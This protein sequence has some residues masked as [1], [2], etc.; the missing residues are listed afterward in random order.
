M[1]FHNEAGR[2]ADASGKNALLDISAN[3]PRAQGVWPGD[4]L[5][6]V[7][8]SP[9][10]AGTIVKL[11]FA[12]RVSATGQ[13][14]WRLEF[15]DGEEWKIVGQSYTNP[16]VSGPDGLPV[17]YT[18]AMESDGSTN[19]KVESLAT[20]SSNTD[21]VEFRF[22][23]AANYKANDSG[24]LPAPN[25]GTWRLAVDETVADAV[26]DDPYQ[27]QISIV[28]AGAETLTKAN[29]QVTPQYLVFEGTGGSSRKFSVDCDQDFTLT[30]S[31]DWIHLN[32]TES[33]AGNELSFSVSCDD[34]P[35]GL[36]R[37][38]TVTVK[39]GF[40]RADI[41]IIQ[42]AAGG[43]IAPDLDPLISVVGGN[44]VDVP[45]Q[46]GSVTV[47]V[48]SN[49]E[50]AALAEDSWLSV[51]AL[52]STKAEVGVKE[53]SVSYTANSDNVNA[54]QG[55][56]VFYN[57]S[58][59]LEAVLTVTQ[60]RNISGEDLSAKFPIVWSFP[61]PSDSW[62]SGVDYLLMTHS[63]S[64]TY[65]YS[66]DHTG[67]IE[68]VRAGTNASLSDPTYLVKTDVTDVG[69]GKTNERMLLH[70]G[71]GPTSYWQFTVENV[72]QG[73]GTYN[74]RYKMC[75]SAGGAK[76]FRL[77]YTLEDDWSNPVPIGATSQAKI[78]MDS[79][80]LQ[81]YT[82]ATPS[83]N[84]AVQVDQSFTLPAIE[85]YKTLKIRAIVVSAVNCGQTKDCAVNT[86][87][88]NRIFGTPTISFTAN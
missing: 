47:K 82:Y 9:V 57:L 52:P 32:S 43:T 6:I 67:K 84:T 22:I 70:Y 1:T 88:T 42:S 37:E 58:E 15:R 69:G 4:Y 24:A 11:V 3:C 10:S 29:L 12:T 65:I 31:N 73:A 5:E 79:D 27:P 34:N 54:R 13:K 7:A 14:Y 23:C 40:T 63:D 68:V 59:G 17:V 61:A 75:S 62:K 87:A 38:G 60:E 80:E 77:E 44:S 35:Q 8:S 41:A 83:G 26:P 16:E 39:A 72:K 33:G 51:A 53:F 55:S 86:T 36:V 66:D 45:F 64:G 85:E 49:V 76:Y 74:I 48:Q 2:A 28:A 78:S 56:V 25:T 50:V 21:Q 30:A 46:A 18:H 81:A 20:Y 71:I 19:I